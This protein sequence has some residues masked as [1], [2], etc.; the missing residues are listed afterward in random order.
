MLSLDLYLMLVFRHLYNANTATAEDI[1]I[2][3]TEM[4]RAAA[5]TK[6]LFRTRVLTE[7]MYLRAMNAPPLLQLL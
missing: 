4:L 1:A 7:K 5:S 2:A 3:S 6:K